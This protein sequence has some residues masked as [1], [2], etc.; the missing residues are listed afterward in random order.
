MGKGSLLAAVVSLGLVG[1][2]IGMV[3]ATIYLTL[4]EPALPV[5]ADPTFILRNYA[6]LQSARPDAFLI[7]NLFA[8]VSVA[9]W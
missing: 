8:G 7:V 3:L 2:A 1:A 9:S 6:W 5:D 4:A